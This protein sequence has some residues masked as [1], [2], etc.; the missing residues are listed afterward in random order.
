MNKRLK[1]MEIKEPRE[2]CPEP[3][4]CLECTPKSNHDFEEYVTYVTST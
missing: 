4:D 2:I 1:Y 3:R